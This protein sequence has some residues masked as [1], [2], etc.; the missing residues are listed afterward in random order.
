MSI[1][2]TDYFYL[3]RIGVQE[4]EVVV[5]F[6][7]AREVG[8]ALAIEGQLARRDDRLEGEVVSVLRFALHQLKL[9]ETP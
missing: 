8:D 4:K 5:D 2:T 7:F 6:E 3:S 1:G 9:F